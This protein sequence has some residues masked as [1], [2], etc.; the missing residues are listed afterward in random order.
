MPMID[1]YIAK[2]II[3]GTQQGL[4]IKSSKSNSNLTG[5]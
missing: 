3:T 1:T 5:I 4:E 2:P